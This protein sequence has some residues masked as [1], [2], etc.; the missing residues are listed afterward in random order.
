MEVFRAQ[1][2]V[3]R[4]Q[5]AL[6][7]PIV[8]QHAEAVV[9]HRKRDAQLDAIAVRT[10]LQGAVDAGFGNRGLLV[11]LARIDAARCQGPRAG[12]G[13]E[14]LVLEAVGA[15]KADPDPITERVGVEGVRA[16]GVEN[17]PFISHVQ[18]Y[19][20]H[21][22]EHTGEDAEAILPVVVMAPGGFV[23]RPLI[24]VA[25]QERLCREHDRLKVEGTQGRGRIRVAVQ[26]VCTTLER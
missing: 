8:D 23:L 12:R 20:E 13:E 10:R 16:Y 25:V 15:S 24:R 26:Q 11:E 3:A 21:P 22:L 4:G 17:E 7:V 19:I 14:Y 6:L 5:R 1:H 2:A 18:Q 9:D